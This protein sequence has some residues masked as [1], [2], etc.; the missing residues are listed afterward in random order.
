MKTV[1]I[2]HIIFRCFFALGFFV[3]I[4]S[5]IVTVPTCLSLL[6]QTRA[7]MENAKS[8]GGDFNFMQFFWGYVW[9]LSIPLT[10]LIVTALGFVFTK[11]LVRFVIGNQ[12]FSQL[13]RM[14]KN[15]S[16]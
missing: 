4:L 6:A 2:T 5:A 13:V 7:V 15:Q 12:V 10:I 8:F 1:L 3:G 16:A 9:I 11:Q 14:D